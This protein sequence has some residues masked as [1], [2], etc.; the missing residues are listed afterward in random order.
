MDG[1]SEWLS[2]QFLCPARP[3]ICPCHC[4]PNW[5]NGWGVRLIFP[6]LEWF[7]LPERWLDERIPSFLAE[8]S[9]PSYDSHCSP[10]K[11]SVYKGL[12]FLPKA[13][14]IVPPIPQRINRLSLLA[15]SALFHPPV[16]CRASPGPLLS[17]QKCLYEIE[18]FKWNY[19]VCLKLKYLYEINIFWGKWNV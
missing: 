9:F 16:S 2:Q 19:N 6:L 1:W 18:M 3:S 17:P 11:I 7:W 12:P 5:P 4:L 10:T 14:L 8:W 13:V 15:S